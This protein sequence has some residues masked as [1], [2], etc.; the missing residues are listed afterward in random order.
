MAFG[1]DRRASAAPARRAAAV[2]RVDGPLEL[3]LHAVVASPT[4]GAAAC[5][6]ATTGAR[7]S[8]A[9]RPRPGGRRRWDRRAR[10]RAGGPRRRR[11]SR[12][13]RAPRWCARGSRRAARRRAG[14]FSWSREKLEAAV[15]TRGDVGDR[16][17][18]RRR[19]PSGGRASPPFR[20]YH[21]RSACGESICDRGPVFRS[22]AI[23]SSFSSSSSAWRLRRRRPASAA[24]QTL[25]RRASTFGSGQRAHRRARRP[26]PGKAGRLG[27]RGRRRS[28]PHRRRAAR[29][30][31]RAS[32]LAGGNGD[33][34][35]RVPRGV[36]R[37]RGS[38]GARAR[39]TSCSFPPTT[40][41]ASAS[42]RLAHRSLHRPSG[43]AAD[44]ARRRR[45][46]GSRGRSRARA[47][48]AA[49]RSRASRPLSRRRD[50]RPRS[51]RV[52]G[53]RR[54]HDRRGGHPADPDERG[55]DDA[56]ARR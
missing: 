32:D 18:Q 30:R 16:Q 2:Q 14:S 20:G 6:R 50:D 49:L 13:G 56:R 43:V 27:D 29:R 7:A 19:R 22:C 17:E 28:A 25:R 36:L 10:R 34:R 41:R 54:R 1:D 39:R 5:N 24:A 47:G 52:D 44:G 35:Q 4:T 9:P 42:P 12:R 15:G 26:R 55:G 48:D 11:W 21:A 53:G 31:H 8:S 46:P 38:A 37:R 40:P 33:P 51:G 45:P 3:R 23:T